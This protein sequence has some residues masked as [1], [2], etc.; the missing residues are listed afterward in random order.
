MIKICSKCH[1]E[2]DLDKDFYKH[3]TN[4]DGHSGACKTCHVKSSAKWCRDNPSA[5]VA[6]NAKWRTTN[7]LANMLS[8]V[9]TYSKKY[10]IP[11]SLTLSDVILPTHCPVFGFPLVFNRGGGGPASNSPSL[12][13]IIPTLGYVQ[14]NVQ[15]LSNLANTMKQNATPEQLILFA[16]WILTDKTL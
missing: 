5:R 2:K 12:D 6:S 10:N 16:K 15:I 8:N 13:R 4:K 14:G 3:A 7:P 11:F 1:L 9:K